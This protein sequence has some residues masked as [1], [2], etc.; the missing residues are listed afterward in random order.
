MIESEILE[1]ASRGL[2]NFPNP[3]EGENYQTVNNR[4]KGRSFLKCYLDCQPIF[5]KHP[6]YY[7]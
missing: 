6:H 4:D 7:F 3:G 1:Q 5:Q 2:L